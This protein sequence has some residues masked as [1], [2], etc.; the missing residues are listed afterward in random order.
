MRSAVGAGR[1]R[2]VRD[3]LG[4]CERSNVMVVVPSRA[5]RKLGG[6]PVWLAGVLD[7]DAVTDV[8][9]WLAGGGPGAAVAPDGLRH[10][11]FARPT[12]GSAARR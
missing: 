10:L 6:R 9:A 3:C 5:G 7:E 2:V 8:I 11:A 12:N 1:V 4:P